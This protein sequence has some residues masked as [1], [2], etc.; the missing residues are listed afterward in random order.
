MMNNFQRYDRKYIC[1][2]VQ[3][4]YDNPLHDE[5]MGSVCYP[6]YIKKGERAWILYQYA[7][8]KYPHRLHTSTVS[9]SFME[10]IL[11]ESGKVVTGYRLTVQTENTEYIFETSYK[12]NES[13]V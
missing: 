10:E 5:V 2:S 11:D 1:T 8:E 9:D 6:A 7:D 4:T 3:S 12:E 13:G